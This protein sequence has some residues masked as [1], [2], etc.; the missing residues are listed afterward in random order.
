MPT[1]YQRNAK[2][3]PK[4][5]QF[6]ANAMPMGEIVCGRD[7]EESLYGGLRM[8]SVRKGVQWELFLWDASIGILLLVGVQQEALCEE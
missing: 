6:N 5:Y 7:Q 2:P 8:E 4:R 1:Q 3:M